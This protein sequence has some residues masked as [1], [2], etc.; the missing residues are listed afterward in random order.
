MHGHDRDA[1]S[2]MALAAKEAMAADRLEAFADKGYYK[3]EEILA[4]DE[5]GIAVVV[6]KPLT[7]NAGAHG[8]FDKADFT[9]Q[10]EADAYTCPAGERLSYRFTSQQDGKTVRT[11]WSDACAGPAAT[12]ATCGA[13]AAGA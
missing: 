1:L 11:Y 12:R 8:R 4:C 10:P 6:P 2:T 3:G 9:Y 5:A 7:S 13:S